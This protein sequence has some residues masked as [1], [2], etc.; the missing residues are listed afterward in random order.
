MDAIDLLTRD[1]RAVEELFGQFRSADDDAKRPVAE[2]IIR[3]LSIHA[4]I[5]EEHFYPAVRKQIPTCDALVRHG[6][7]EHQ[8]V[9]ELLATIDGMVDKAHTK[10]FAGKMERL[11][12]SVG[13]HVEE[14]EGKLFPS[15]REAF[16]KTALNELGTAMNKGK[17]MATTRPHPNTPA[18]PAVHATVGRAVA[19]VDRMRDEIAGRGEN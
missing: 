7:D 18:H 5:E 14:E 8:E 6:I 13:E 19:A 17:S 10:A 12:K 3:E 15:V 2:N 1:H 16:T 9:K 11:E 4:A